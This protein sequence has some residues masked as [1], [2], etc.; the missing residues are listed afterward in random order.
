[1]LNSSSSLVSETGKFSLGFFENG[2]SKS[3][4]L[5]IYHTN[6]GN[7]INYAW[8]ANRKTPILYPTG[9]LALDENNTL[10]V[11]Q[12][13]GDPLLLYSANSE[14]SASNTSVVA[15]LLDSGNFTLLQ[16]NSDG[17]TKRV[18]WQS[19]DHPGNT[20]LPGMKLG[21][22]RKNGHIWSLSSW[23][24]LY[25]AEPGAFTLDWDPSEHQ[26]KIR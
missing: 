9:V 6:A 1:M 19:F 26:L 21:I 17:S 3:S 23:L 25:S 7:T 10:K 14:S 20:L 12:N 4:Y 24:S 15:T 8:I 13:G 22:D 11:T 16:V 5:A 18:L 2:I